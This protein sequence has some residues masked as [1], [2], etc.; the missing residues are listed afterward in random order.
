[1]NFVPEIE[2]LFGLLCFFGSMFA[3]SYPAI[4]F[5]ECGHAFAAH[6]FGF[7]P[8]SIEIGTGKRVLFSYQYR[9]IKLVMKEKPYGGR[10]LYTKMIFTN[11]FWWKQA[12]IAGAG[13]FAD[14]V[15]LIFLSLLLLSSSALG[16][17]TLNKITFGLFFPQFFSLLINLFPRTIRQNGKSYPNDTKRM[18]L[19]L[20]GKEQKRNKAAIEGVTKILM[21]YDQHYRPDASSGFFTD[22]GTLLYQYLEAKKFLEEMQFDNALANFKAMLNSNLLQNAEKAYILDNMACLPTFYGQKQYLTEA[23]S[24][25]EEAMRLAPSSR[26]LQGTYG[27]LLIESDQIDRAIEVLRTVVDEDG[28][29]LVRAMASGYLAQAYER[30]GNQEQTEFWLQR[31]VALEAQL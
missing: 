19:C 15:I 2:Y 28:E 4:F 8:H 23:F 1:M 20:T 16:N 13:L 30:L 10:T 9:T 25:I 17:N 29:A 5:H 31:Q 6:L 3:W 14:G 12:I 26:T 18:W 7:T 24:W 22:E 27:G 21:L 11:G